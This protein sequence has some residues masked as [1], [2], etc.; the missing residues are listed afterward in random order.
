MSRAPQE[1]LV[2]FLSDMYSVEQQALAQ[3]VSAPKIAGDPALAGDFRL[4]HTETEQQADLVRERL[5]ALG[6]SPSKLKDAVMRLGGKGFLLFA[7]IMPETPGRLVDHA[8][9][10]EALEWAGY[11][12]LIRFAECAGD[13]KTVEV[14][15]LIRDQERA[16]MQRLEHGFDAAERVSHADLSSD[17]IND[18]LVKHLTEVHAFE[19]QNIQLLEKSA[20]IAG[21]ELLAD[22]Y[23]RDLDQIRKHAKLVEARVEAL[24]SSSSKLKDSALALGGLNW[25]LFFQAQ[26]DT[27]AKLAAFVYAVLHLEI[28]GY[29]LLKRTA[30]R[31]GDSET[32]QLCET[33][34]AE[35]RAMANRLAD[36]FTSAVQAT[37]AELKP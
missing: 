24:D 26:S 16:M 34:I 22:I 11:E 18:H 30:Q 27:P 33:L 9:S 25:G 15:K 6:G 14:A 17:K 3:M 21:N 12:M 35:K 8:Y 4:H 23:K 1:Q 19:S 20:D 10:Y 31:I 29:E 28:G 37:L 7:R 32:K 5:E 2:H 13:P 36:S